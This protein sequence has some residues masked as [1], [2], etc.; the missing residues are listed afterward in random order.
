M[1]NKCL[2]IHT[3]QTVYAA[4]ARVPP[5]KT[6]SQ[7][8]LNTGK[9]CLVKPR[10]PRGPSKRSFSALQSRRIKASHSPWKGAS[11]LLW[12]AVASP[13]QGQVVL[14]PPQAGRGRCS[15]LA[16]FVT[17]GRLLLCG[18]PARARLL[19]AILLHLFLG[20][21][22]FHL[23]CQ[24]GHVMDGHAARLGASPF[25]RSSNRHNRLQVFH[26]L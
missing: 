14:S 11:L 10:R 5:P 8:W 23:S 6:V 22:A 25:H 17:R 16:G 18:V 4:A 13:M 7:V 3:L 20:R 2:L 9:K 1:S 15:L 19:I 26:L 21:I 12:K 24:R